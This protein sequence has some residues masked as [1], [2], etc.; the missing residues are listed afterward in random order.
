MNERTVSPCPSVG[1]VVGTFAAV[2]YVHLHLEAARRFE[3]GL[4]LLVH[5]DRSPHLARLRKLAEE[6][7]CEC[8]STVRRKSHSYGDMA[9]FSAGL[10]WAEARDVELLV[11][12]SRRFVPL[13]S[14]SL[15][16][17]R[18]ARRLQYATYSS[19]CTAHGFGFGFRTECLALHVP[20]WLS[21]DALLQIKR[22]G[23]RGGDIL[24]EAFLHDLSHRVHASTQCEQNRRPEELFPPAGASRRVR[25]LVDRRHLQGNCG[26]PT[27]SGTTGTR[28][29]TTPRSRSSG[30]FRTPCKTSKDP[31]VGLGLG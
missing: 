11:K 2:P 21:T 4:P 29:R 9:A 30:D 17:Q 14:W 23:A 19:P 27:S 13:Y 1:M 22:R 10:R 12:F 6:Y 15:D 31:N 28:P 5:D 3:P 18:L 26:S 20:A 24:V 8:V 16:L 25:R 7:G